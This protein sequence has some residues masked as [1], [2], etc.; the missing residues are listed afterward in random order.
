MSEAPAPAP[1]PPLWRRVLPF[2]IALALLAWV[3]SRIERDAFFDALAATSPLLYVGFAIAFTLALLLADAFA[4]AGVYRALVADV[5]TLDL[6]VVRGASYLPSLLNH[7]IGQAWLTWFVA[8][9]K[10]ASLWR[11]TGATLVVYATTFGG[12]WALALAGGVLAGDRVPWLPPT[13]IGLG[14]AAVAYLIVI[15]ARPEV[16]ARR[17]ALAPLFE[18]GVTGQLLH[19]ARRLPHVAVLFAGTWIP[20]ELF[21][22]HLGPADALARIPVIMLVVALPLTPQGL[23]TRD[24]IAV[25]LLAGFHASEDPRAA[26]SAV[27]ACTLSWGVLLT[28]IQAPLGLVLMTAA[29]RRMNR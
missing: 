17:P 1:P 3:A 23:G 7:H 22:I 29:K 18:L 19:F 4:T 12:L 28:L 24:A 10:G 2:G 20:F 11:T 8:R 6:F 25:T 9:S 27:L 16:L 5:S 26:E 13:V 14:V 21:G 15:A